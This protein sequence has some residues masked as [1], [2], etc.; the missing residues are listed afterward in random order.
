LQ[1][2]PAGTYVTYV[3]AEDKDEGTNGVVE[4]EF[5]QNK[6]GSQD[7]KKFTIDRK[8]GNITTATV[9]DREEQEIYLVRAYN[10]VKLKHCNHVQ[11]LSLYNR[12]LLSS[13]T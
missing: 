10:V 6:V 11:Y 4:Y 9:L 1:N 2:L 8:T 5:V 12:S 3:L 13:I 7:Y